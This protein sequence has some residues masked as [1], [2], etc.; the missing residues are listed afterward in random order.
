MLYSILILCII[1]AQPI[2]FQDMAGKVFIIDD[3][4]CLQKGRQAVSD[5]VLT[6]VDADGASCEVNQHLLTHHILL[7]CSPRSNHRRWLTQMVQE[8]GAVFLMEPWS[9]EESIVA[10]FVYSA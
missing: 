9:R 10:S 2:V 8:E 1:C 3:A 6:L 7:T 5:D 4:M